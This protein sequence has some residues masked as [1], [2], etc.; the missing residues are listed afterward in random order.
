MNHEIKSNLIDNEFH[1]SIIK[2][3]KLFADSVTYPGIIGKSW[4]IKLFMNLL[5]IF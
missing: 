3:D 4:N 1:N 2:Y 5:T